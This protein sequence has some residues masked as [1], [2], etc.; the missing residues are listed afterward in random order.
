MWGTT[1]VAIVTAAVPIVATNNALG[2]EHTLADLQW[3]N[4]G[5]VGVSDTFTTIPQC[6]ADVESEWGFKA[7]GCMDPFPLK[8]PNSKLPMSGLYA[9][10][11]RR[12]SPGANM[13]VSPVESNHF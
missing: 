10:D 3:L 5:H 11:I 4:Q 8:T 9:I 2:K 12:T 6:C 13:L 7:A 1:M